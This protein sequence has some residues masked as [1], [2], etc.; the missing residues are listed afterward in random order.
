MIKVVILGGGTGQSVILRGIK[1]VEGIE[2]ATIV[3]VADD[4]G[5]TGRL[6][7]EFSMPAMGDIRNVMVSLSDEQS[8]MSSIMD[9][10][11][12]VVDS[13]SLGGHSLGNL[14]LTALTQT[15]GS[16][17]EAIGSVS[18]IMKVKGR[19]IPSSLQLLTLLAR[20][21]DGTIV[22]GESNI[23]LFK[24]AITEVFYDEPVR[25]T[26]E[27]IDAIVNADVILFGIGSLFTSILPNVAIPDI[28]RALEFTKAK[29]VYYCNAMTQPGETDGY[30]GEDHVDAILR[31][32]NI[33]F[34]F[35]VENITKTDE[36]LAK[37]YL[38]TGS[39]GVHFEK[40]EHEYRLVKHDL[41]KTGV[42]Q[43]RHDSVK[44]KASF[45]ALLK[46]MGYVV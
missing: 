11:F 33:K 37:R 9:Y 43:I 39:K 3:T 45:E 42:D 15:T 41:L 35:V 13:E 46:E 23:P 29:K 4:G 36:N 2:L 31:H 28:R 1:Q 17:M 26:E 21:E 19:I 34:D 7:D 18:K 20:M 40:T 38:E 25:A 32:C 12:N 10:R 44:V 30:N 22:R 16:F 5:S 27:S 14:I 24:N 6:R 8:L